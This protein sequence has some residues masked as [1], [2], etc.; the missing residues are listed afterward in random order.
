MCPQPHPPD[1]SQE[2]NP[3]SRALPARCHEPLNLLL[4]I[5]IFTSP[6]EATIAS[7]RSSAT[8]TVSTISRSLIGTAPSVRS[9][10]PVSC[11]TGKPDTHLSVHVSQ[12]AFSRL[13]RAP[14]AY[15]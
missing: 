13:D 5:L 1:T 3:S 2:K 15:G 10:S 4:P 12:A 9:Q 6:S 14:A 8:K 11:L 7:A